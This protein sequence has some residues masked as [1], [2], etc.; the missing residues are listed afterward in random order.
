MNV[1]VWNENRHE[2]QNDKVAG[3]YPDGIHGAIAAFLREA[4]LDTKT[5]TL[6]EPEHGLTDEVLADTDVL[7]WWGHKA[8]NEVKDEIAE[9]VKQRVLDGMGLVV[10]HSAHFSK[11]F[12]KLMGTTCD[13]KWR[14]ADDRERLWVVDPSHSITEGLGEYIELEKEEMYGEHFDIPTPDQ[15]L[16]VSWFEGGEVF[17]SGATFKRGKG[18]IFY[19][20]P[21]HETYP[22]YHNKEIQQVITNGVNWAANKNTPSPTY[23]NRKQLEKIS[24]K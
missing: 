21:G 7:V 19:F 10:L 23:G 15:L 18:K 2:K 9:K 3:I 5:A 17:R 24:D 13:L 20:R 4:G 8:H 14:E 16:F 1:T 22:T 12:K 6:D 11:V